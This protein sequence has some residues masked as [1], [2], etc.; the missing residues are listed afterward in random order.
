MIPCNHGTLHFN[1]WEWPRISQI[2]SF[3]DSRGNKTVNENT[4]QCIGEYCS[5]F[6]CADLSGEQ[7]MIAPTRTMKLDT[8]LRTVN[9]PM[10]VF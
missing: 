5:I 3:K 9:T 7:I 8:R 1:E 4:W 6:P 2:Y 10:E